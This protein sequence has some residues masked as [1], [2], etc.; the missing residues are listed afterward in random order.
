MSKP[1]TLALLIAIGV[2]ASGC[3]TRR[4]DGPPATAEGPPAA[5]DRACPIDGPGPGKGGVCIA[6]RGP[7]WTYAFVYPAEA[8]RIPALDAWLRNESKGDEGDHEESIGSLA[9]WAKQNPDGK[10]HLER[11]YTLDSDVPALLALSKMTSSYTGGP[12]GWFAL[13]TLLWDKSRNRVLKSEELFSD[14]SAANAEIRDQLCPALIELRRSR[15]RGFNGRCEEPPYH[16]L[17]LLAAGGRVT[18]LKVT[19]NELEGYAGGTYM[20]YVPVTRRLLE[21]V[22]ERFRAGFAVSAAPPR[23]C[24]ND[25][26]CIERRPPR[27]QPQ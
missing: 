4:P 20:V 22:A 8:A 7:N 10:F 24:N 3:G 11:V 26:D 14:P 16:T 19:F 12:H 27:L 17:A 2:N 6:K 9:A 5:A 25:V 21:L 13:E 15:N 23:A 18:T 1:L